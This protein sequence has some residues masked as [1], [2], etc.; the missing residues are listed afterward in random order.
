MHDFCPFLTVHHTSPF[1]SSIL[2]ENLFFAMPRP[3]F[4]TSAPTTRG[5]VRLAFTFSLLQYFDE[6]KLKM[7]K[8]ETRPCRIKIVLLEA[9]LGVMRMRDAGCEMQDDYCT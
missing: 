6:S 9:G 5:S 4:R 2:V 7:G 3:R 1:I 8:V